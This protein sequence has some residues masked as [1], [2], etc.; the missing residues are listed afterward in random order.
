MIY[1]YIYTQIKNAGQP[2][3]L[4][5]FTSPTEGMSHL[6][7]NTPRTPPTQSRHAAQVLSHQVTTHREPQPVSRQSLLLRSAVVPAAR[8]LVAKSGTSDDW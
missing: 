1:I 6:T 7:I 4:C 5:L 3:R 8:H 2:V